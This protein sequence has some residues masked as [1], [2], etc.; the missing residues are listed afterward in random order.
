MAGEATFG[1]EVTYMVKETGV[2]LTKV[3]HSEYLARKFVNR[4]VHGK[5]CVLVSCPLFS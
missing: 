3:F 5:R 4:V 1:Y 2:V